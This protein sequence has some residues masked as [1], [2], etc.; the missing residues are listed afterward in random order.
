MARRSRFVMHFIATLALFGGAPSAFA[1]LAI[2]PAMDITQ[3]VRVQ[4]IIVANDNGT[5]PAESFGN[6]G[7]QS[8]IE[9]FIDDIWA[10]AG[11]D[12]DFLPSTNWNSTFA[13]DGPG[14]FRTID[15]ANA[16]GVNNSDPNVINMYFVNM[17]GGSAP[18]ENSA[19]G[20]GVV[21]G[22][23]VTQFVGTNLLSFTGGQE[24]IASVVA[25]EIGHNLG[26][27]H[28]VMAENL[29]QAAGSTND[30]ERLN[31]SQITTALNSGL[32]TV[33]TNPPPP[34]PLPAAAW[35]FGS[36]LIGLVGVKRRRC[37]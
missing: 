34:I 15:A 14:L 20:V 10:Q 17:I 7:Q 9:G 25:H 30:G 19:S 29:M 12:V 24:V 23:G 16:A 6:S 31:S 22:N 1:A 35:L 32:S 11:I 18:G 37:A 27:N 28:I 8:I 21:G 5:S 33:L 36:A 4:P 26:L 13:N 3:L 2:N